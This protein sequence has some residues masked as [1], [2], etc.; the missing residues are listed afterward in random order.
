MIGYAGRRLLLLLPVLWMAAT[1]VWAALFLVPGDPVRLLA[2]K[3][4]DPEVVAR[5]RAD[6]GLHEPPM[7][8]YGRFLWRLVHLD[9]GHSYVQRRPVA[10]ILGDHLVPTLVLA[11]SAVALSLLL[12]LTLGA[13]AAARRG[14]WLDRAVQ[15]FALL[16]LSTPVFW[17][18]LMLMLAF[19]SSRGLGWLPVSGYGEAGGGGSRLGL[20]D[21][22]HLLLP[23]LS[24]ALMSAGA[25]TRMTRASLL[26]VLGQ[27]YVRA[28][29]ARG[30]PPVR[31][32]GR[33]ALRNALVPVVT[34]AGLDLA[35]LVGGAI[36]TESVFAWPGLGRT[37]VHAIHLRDLPVVEGGVLVMTAG[38]VLVTLLVDVG[39]G[40]IDPRTRDA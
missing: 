31:V 14:T 38:F 33:H 12:S 7:V 11:A 5:I 36:V 28:A 17:L 2:G 13:L 37:M 40:W 18:G 25:L 24:L 9:L 8:Q 30:L 10:E 21:F 23:A 6:W 35:A 34:L 4:A 39:Y 3:T 32:L 22:S 19:A 27:D 1:V 29:T 26:D 15:G 20:P 16:S